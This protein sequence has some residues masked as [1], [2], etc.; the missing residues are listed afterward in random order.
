MFFVKLSPGLSEFSRVFAVLEELEGLL[1][2]YLLLLQQLVLLL[3][4][5]TFTVSCGVSWQTST[6]VIPYRLMV[7]TFSR[8]SAVG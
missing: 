8:K 3:Q 2:G 5:C 6:S 1:V 7:A 4:G